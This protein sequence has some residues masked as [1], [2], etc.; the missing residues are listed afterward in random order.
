[1]TPR[2]TPRS[3][4]VL[5]EG[6][7]CRSPIAEGLLRAGLGSGIRVESAGLN[8]ENGYGPH[9]EAVRLMAERGLDI[10]RHR[11]RLL[12]PDMALRAD[13][14]LV[15]DRTQKT[16]CELL[17][18]STRGRVFLFG[19]W[20]PQDRQEIPDPMNKPKE[21]FAPVFESLLQAADVWRNELSAG[22]TP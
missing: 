8:A 15:M 17:M 10:S 5:C 4:L 3:I 18:P 22:R 13:L 21:A 6:N 20:L 19:C 2:F 14:I 9:P 1:M 12:T 11:S 7:H 16:W